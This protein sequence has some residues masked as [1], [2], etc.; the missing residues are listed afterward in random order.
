MN[1]FKNN[2]S[3]LIVGTIFIFPVLFYVLLSI[4]KHSYT[5]LSYYNK[6]QKVVD[7]KEAIVLDNAY[8]LNQNN[9]SI[10]IEKNRG[11]ITIWGVL[12][13]HDFLI[14]PAIIANLQFL[15]ERFKDRSELQ[16]FSLI[17]NSTNEEEIQEFVQTLNIDTHNW[18]ILYSDSLSNNSFAQNRL[19]IK[20]KT[21]PDSLSQVVPSSDLVLVDQNLHIRGYFQGAVH[22]E[23]KEQLLDAIDM[24]IREQ[25]V[26]Y[27]KKRPSIKS[28][29]TDE[30]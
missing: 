27:K 26:V 1:F 10:A 12:N 22:K 11:K 17:A 20:Y 15:Q 9:D 2:K 4:G 18:Q 5:R 7:I 29:L 16:F 30:K 24:L 19:F 28:I 3:K 13:T 21:L 25:Y 8:F 14:T 23:V 6:E